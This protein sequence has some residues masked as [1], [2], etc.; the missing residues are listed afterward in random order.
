MARKYCSQTQSYSHIN[1]CGCGPPWE[2]APRGMRRQPAI[3]V[4]AR[5]PKAPK[6]HTHNYQPAG[7]PFTEM[8]ED[9]HYL[10]QKQHCDVPGCSQPDYTE[11]LTQ[12][13]RV[14]KHAH[15]WNSTPSRTWFKRGR[16]YALHECTVP[17]CSETKTVSS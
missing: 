9:Y 7:R 2:P 13:V 1:G 16:G 6:G 10:R 14:R 3:P 15:A 11:T 17:G 5:V 4:A 8:D 12:I